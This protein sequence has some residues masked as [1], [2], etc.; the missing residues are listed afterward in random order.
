MSSDRA[1]PA[2]L[3]P[4]AVVAAL[5]ALVAGY[6]N[7]C[8]AGLGFAPTPGGKVEETRDKVQEKVK[9]TADAIARPVV[10]EQGE[11]CRLGDAP[12]RECAEVCGEQASGAEVDVDGTEGTH[13]AVEA[14]HECLKGRGVKVKRMHSE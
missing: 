10:V 9:Q 2:R 6:L 7:D 12:L 8:F 3:G 4:L 11:R 14:L 13:R 5:V 1:R